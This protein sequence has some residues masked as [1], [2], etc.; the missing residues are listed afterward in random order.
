[1]ID[2]LGYVFGYTTE[3]SFLQELKYNQP[4]FLKMGKAK[5]LFIFIILQNK[6][7]EKITSATACKDL[8][9]KFKVWKEN[10]KILP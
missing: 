6:T 3:T 10:T 2:A 7:D 5:K 4:K 8:V 1:M 9:A